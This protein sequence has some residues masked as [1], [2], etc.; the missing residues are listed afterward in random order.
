MISIPFVWRRPHGFAAFALV[1]AVAGCATTAGSSSQASFEV[2]LPG[3]GPSHPGAS[4]REDERA[5]S[6]AELDGG[7]YVRAVLRGN[8]SLESARQGWRAALA[9]ARQAGGFEDPMLDVAV[10]PLSIGSSRA[11]LGYELGISQKVPWFGKRSLDASVAA[12]EAAASKSDYESVKR[13]LALSALVLFEQYF[14]AARSL[15]INAH[16]IELMR[17]ML[18]SA[19]AQFV[20]GRG[21]AQDTLQAESELA[22]MEHDTAILT[23]QR[24]VI[25]A[26][27]NELLHRSPELPLPP[28]P[29][30]LPL[31]A[32]FD[33]EPKRLEAEAVEARPE[34]AAA[35][36]HVQA[37]QA[38]ADRAA[39][40]Y[41]P[42]LTISTSYNSMWDT[43]EHRWM[44]G[45]GLNLPIQ[46]GRR[47]GMA[48]EA[49][50][51]RA[52]FESEAARL[53]DAARTQAFVALK[54]LEESRH[55]LA[56]FESRLMPLA[57]E[58]VEA[59]RSG[60]VSSQ[61][62]FAMAID[63]EKNLRGVELDYQVARAEC[64]RRQAELERALGRIPGIAGKE[65]ER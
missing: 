51:A 55:V 24:D 47:A 21:S 33:A 45:V 4:S 41:Y 20:A 32:R 31:T 52:E 30:D 37:E 5:V 6:G 7:A 11:P 1:C 44:V 2:D 25:V 16:H 8:P 46:T 56:V 13:E 34:I 42:D 43:P 18:D 59:A 39:R 58:R 14:V 17:A 61:S 28:P 10:A 63:A 12:A 22:H 53:T 65:V 36:E 49:I 23:S 60:F 15:E 54:Q 29:R 27:M 35:R 19:T 62:S 48:D 3:S 57:K 40:D 50:A 64:H 38:R 9:R 26:Q